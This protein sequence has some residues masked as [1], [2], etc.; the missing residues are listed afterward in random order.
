MWN[1]GT[2][3]FVPEESASVTSLDIPEALKQLGIEEP[4]FPTWLPEGFVLAEQKIQMDELSGVRPASAP[5]FPGSVVLCI[6]L[7]VFPGDKQIRIL[8]R[9]GLT[10]DTKGL[11]YLLQQL[12]AA[13]GGHF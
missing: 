2:F 11:L 5:K 12:S 8:E 10:A 3:Q 13:A 9:N 4:L 1:D 6:L 7:Q